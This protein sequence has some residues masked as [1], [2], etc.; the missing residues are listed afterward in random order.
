MKFYDHQ[1]KIIDA[2]VPKRGKW[3]G[4]GTGKTRTALA[5]SRGTALV[6]CPKTQK[7]DGNWERELVNLAVDAGKVYDITDVPMDALTT[8]TFDMFKRDHETLPRFDTV[9]VDEAHGMFGVTP[10]TRFRKKVEIPK[11]SQRFEA[12]D[13]YLERTK[14]DRYYPCSATIIKSPFTVWAA[15]KTLANPVMRYDMTGFYAFRHEFYTRLPMPGREV[16]VPK[17]DAATKEKLAAIVRELGDIGRL[18]DFFDV[19]EQTFIT[20]K[21]ELTQQQK[22]RIKELRFEY[23]EPIV[24]IGKKHQVE[25]GVLAPDEFSP[26]ET[27]AN[28]KIDAILEYAAEFPRMVVF[29]KYRAQINAIQEALTDAGY[30]TWTLAGDTKDRKEVIR[31]ANELDG[32]LI[33]QAQ[34]SAGWEVKP[35]PVMIFASRT[36]SWVDYDQALGRIQRADAI[37]KNLYINLVARGGVDEAVDRALLNKQDFNERIYAEA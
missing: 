5:L 30:H 28:G 14:P 29:A 15:G 25:N 33:C 20:K 9:I 10:N 17:T 6:I 24:R 11:A 34:I 7:D 35:T 22:D 13:A 3:L 1:Q 31:Q 19:P 37:K 4:T 21:I 36:Y 26:G 8:I 12:L 32:V 23:P 2:D 16:Y 27:F 18:E